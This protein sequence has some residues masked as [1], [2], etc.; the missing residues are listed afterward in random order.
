MEEWKEGQKYMKKM[1]ICIMN[2]R[3]TPKRPQHII[4]AAFEISVDER[5]MFNLKY[6]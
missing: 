5:K 4:S 3:N 6:M 1:I 2:E